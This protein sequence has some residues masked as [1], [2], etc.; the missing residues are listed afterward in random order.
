[1]TIIKEKIELLPPALAIKFFMNRLPEEH[2]Q[3]KYLENQH[4]RKTAGE[5]GESKLQKQFREFYLEE[6]HIALWDIGL[7]LGEWQT[8]FDGLVVTEKCVVILESKNVSD[9]LYFNRETGEFIRINAK[10]ERLVL[11]DPVYQL[12][13]NIQFLTLWFKQF[14]LDVEVTGLIVYTAA[15]CIFHSKPPGARLCKIYQMNA[16]LYD[17]LQS[18]P[19]DRTPLNINKIRRLLELNDSP[20]VRKPLCKTYQISYEDLR[21]GVYCADCHEYLMVRRHRNWICRKCSSKNTTAHHFA[22]QEYFT[23]VNDSIT[24]KELR[25]FCSL[26]SANVANKILRQY[27]FVVSGDNKARRYRL[28]D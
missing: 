12:K 25:N 13:K 4:H 5:R 10:G 8:Q 3:R 24:N 15:N 20:Y 2:P 14:G 22:L 18:I 16:H 9:D 6:E 19:Q 28:K 23:F 17:L 1:M 11:Q 21:K 7:K 26:E 27:D